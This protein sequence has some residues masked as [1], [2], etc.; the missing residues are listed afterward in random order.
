MTSSAGT[1][2]GAP[3]PPDPVQQARALFRSARELESR[4][5]RASYAEA[6][7]AYL[8][9][10]AANHKALE[11]DAAETAHDLDEVGVAFAHLA[12]PALAVR[13]ADLGLLLAPRS[14]SLLHHKALAYLAQGQNLDQALALLDRALDANA[15]DKA[16]WATKGEVLERLGRV[17][18]AVEAYLRAQQLDATSMQYVE[19]ALRLVPTEPRAL[20][21]KLQLAKAH[22]GDAQA[23]AACDALLVTAP[24]DAEL[25]FARA[26]LLRATGQLTQA[27]AAVEAIQGMRPEDARLDLLRGRLFLGLGRV[28]EAL[29][30]FRKVL[31]ERTAVDASSLREIADAAEGVG[32]DPKMALVARQRLR[33]LEPRN[34]EN[35]NALRS[36]SARLGET[37]LG[38]E[39]CRA[40]LELS[41]GNLQA[42]RALAE[43]YV[44]SGQVDQGLE[45]FRD[46]VRMHPQETPDVRRA[47]EAAKQAHRTEL[48]SEFAG[49]ILKENP[50]DPATLEDVFRARVATGNGAGALEIVNDLLEVRPGDMGYLLEKKRLLLELGDL[51]ALLPVYDEIFRLDPTRSD[52]ALE[53]GERYLQIALHP[54]HEESDREPAARAALV[55]FERASSDP[56]LLDRSLLGLAEALR[57]VKDPARAVAAYQDYLARPGNDRKGEIWKVLGHTLREMDRVT[58]AEVAYGQALQVGDEDADLYWGEAT[59]LSALNQDER[60]LR[61]IDLLLQKDPQ[62]P[63]YLRKRGQIL[64]STGRH[65][66][67]LA[68]LK[69]AV[70]GA[71]GDPHIHFEVARALRDS[72]SYADAFTYYQQGLELD[73]KSVEGRLGLAVTLQLAGRYNEVVPLVDALLKEDPNDLAAWQCR[74]DAFRSLGRP[75][76]VAYSLKAILL[77]DGHNGPALLERFQLHLDQGD[78][79][80]AFDSIDQYLRSS[81]ES[82]HDVG[83]LLRHA[84]LAAEL[85][86]L[87]EANRSY[88]EAAKLDP[89]QLPEI[90][91]RRARVRL[92]AGRPDLA[93]EVL[94]SAGGGSTPPENRSIA[95][96][97]LRAEILLALERPTEAY[98]V[99]EEVL[100]RDAKSV[101]AL[102]GVA[103]SL[104]E[105]AHHQEAKEFVRRSMPLIPPSAEMYLLLA[106]AESG[107]GSLPDATRA[108]QQGVE[109]LPRSSELWTRLAELHIARESWSEAS[110]ALAHAIAV[111]GSDPRLLLRA[112]FVAEKLAHPNEALS[113]YDHATQ[114][115]PTDTNA[116][117]SRGLVLI[118]LGRPEDAQESFD[119]ALAV[120]P[121]FEPAKEGKKLAVQK[122]KETQ[123]DRIGREA[124]LLE[125]RLR[126]AITKNDLFVTLH[127]PYEL[128]EPVLTALSRS[129]TVDLDALSETEL[130]DLE[131]AS[132]HLVMAALQNRSEGI[133][134]QGFSLADVAVFSPPTYSLGQIHRLFGYLRAVLE[135]DLRPENLRLTPDVEELVR[136]AFTMIPD[137][138]RTLFHIVRVLKVGL[139]KARIVKVVESA[140]SA[141]HAPLPSVDLGE[142]A[143]EF[144]ETSAS[145]ETSTDARPPTAASFSPAFTGPTV[146]GNPDPATPAG[147]GADGPGSLSP[148]HVSSGPGIEAPRCVGC[149]GLASFQHDCGATLCQH[150]IAQF[151]TCPKC[152]RSVS[153]TS[154]RTIGPDRPPQKVVPPA[155]SGGFSIRS[156]VGR[157]RS[158]KGEAPPPRAAR[159]IE[160]STT[161][162]LAEPTPPRRLEHPKKADPPKPAAGTPASVGT[163]PAP[164]EPPKPAAVARPP[165]VREKTDDEPRL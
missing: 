95:L 70:L 66:E 104:I 6:L 11:S 137:D 47:L 165:R 87:E 31:S 52:I 16:T 150:C 21:M 50:K 62:N 77:L 109:Q 72:G 80:E 123:V 118:A 134:R 156:V 23:L 61:F 32:Q 112:G 121:E 92:K 25:L 65:A 88:E 111:D 154:G 164:T 122:V 141:V 13:A 158:T 55:S 148:L 20:R 129:P 3:A 43:F 127:V 71:H 17:P 85:G 51:E 128:L 152:G 56:A 35:L 29:V 153:A 53:R 93:L 126:R 146:S 39:S 94:D 5:P 34:I 90:A 159:A 138:Q 130:K 8:D 27:L 76:E 100:G 82:S 64:L 22:G 149:S 162:K 83:L 119:R 24:A 57:L 115:A 68:A 84:D 75:Q 133:E 33:A 10:V 125:A 131:T 89:T 108:V 81:G 41:P 28:D 26:E 12:Q 136:K 2:R 14:P 79:P 139:F 18:E 73:P 99:Y 59:V 161:V 124:L 105:Q 19:Q 46:L 114:V 135:A 67:G 163:G 44:T 63:L 60:A 106:E 58:E 1:S 110:N 37:E 132:Y 36:L 9:H 101:P 74:A 40:L 4:R 107:L 143:S 38:L 98:Q 69:S 147:P 30:Q 96:L 103:R 97:L 15:H 7:R 140:G 117:T 102:I 157:S 54:A 160:R 120:D 144:N 145:P 116:W 49:V 91:A 113:L 45:A 151:H 155:K 78:K 48:V 86:K 42:M 142:Y